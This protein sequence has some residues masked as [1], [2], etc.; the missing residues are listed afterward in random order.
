[1]V[2]HKRLLI[3]SDRIR[4]IS[5]VDRSLSLRDEEIHY[6]R[7]VLRLV[8]GS[9]IEITDGMGHL[10]KGTFHSSRNILFTSL[11][12]NPIKIARRKKPLIGIAV[13]TPRRG[14]DDALRMSCELG[15]D[16]VQLL[17]SEYRTSQP[18]DRF[19]RW[20]TIIKQSIKQSERLWSTEL[21]EIMD[22]QEF[23]ISKASNKSIALSIAV[24][25]EE[26]I[27]D[28]DFLIGNDNRSLEEI[29]LIIG[30]EGGWTLEE[31]NFADLLGVQPLSFGDSILRT[32]TA[33]VIATYIMVSSRD[34]L[35]ING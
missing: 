18:E 27:K 21:I 14:F 28:V 32:V 20:N 35:V 15:V 1:M 5:S 23:L 26:C 16:K 2:L 9:V 34:K 6:L 11:Y 3:E 19:C 31:R 29:W 30:P 22:F 17:S 24:S 4:S 8:E 12:D 7:R 33:T 13:V 10:W 25:R